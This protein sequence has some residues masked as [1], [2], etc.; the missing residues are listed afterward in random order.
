[1][2]ASLL[3]GGNVRAT[4]RIAALHM[5]IQSKLSVLVFTEILRA[6]WRREFS[7]QHDEWTPCNPALGQG[8]STA[9]LAQDKFG[10]EILRAPTA[11]T[12]VHYWNRLEG[13]EVDFTSS[14]FSGDLGRLKGTPVKRAILLESQEAIAALIPERYQLLCDSYERTERALKDYEQRL[15]ATQ[16]GKTPT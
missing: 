3:E 5:R 2:I 6:S 7:A 4:Q 14:Q 8:A 13:N 10:G 15:A 1:M 9:L 16:H 12:L 11:G